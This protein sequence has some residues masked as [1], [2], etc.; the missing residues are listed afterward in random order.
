MPYTA[1][2][3][4]AL[5]AIGRAARR[6]ATHP[7]RAV[8]SDTPTLCGGCAGSG[9]IVNPNNGRP[10]RHHACKGEGVRR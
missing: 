8:T 4:R 9:L 2:H 6:S 5:G 10:E 3:A 7:P 1:H